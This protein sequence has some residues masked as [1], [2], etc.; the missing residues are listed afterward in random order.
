MLLPGST[1]WTDTVPVFL[2]VGVLVFVPGLAAGLLLRLRPLA[3]LAL[4]PLLSTTCLG[5]TAVVAPLVGVR[6]SVATVVV[7]TLALWV[8]AFGAGILLTRAN[9][10]LAARRP[11]WATWLEHPAERRFDPV[12][13]WTV[14]SV[15]VTLLVVLWT[16]RP[17]IRTPEALPQAP[18]TIFHVAAP[19]WGLQHGTLSSLQIGHF[20]DPAA[21]FYPGAFYAFTATASLL[22]GAS[23]VVCTSVYVVLLAGVV[24][25]LGCIVLA[26]S[27]LGRR[28]LVVLAT[29]LLSVAFTT[30]PYFLMGFGVLWPNLLG[31]AIL[32]AALAALVG[33]FRPRATP[34]YAV[35]DRVRSAAVLLVA[36]PG[37][38][39]AHPNAFVTLGV[40]GALIVL[41]RVWEAARSQRSGQR[42]L[43]ILGGAV[44]AL[45]VVAVVSVLVRPQF[46]VDTGAPGPERSVLGA[47]HDLLLFAPRET[48]PLPVLSALV[49]IGVVVLLRRHRGARW[50]VAALVVMLAL[51]WLNI[52]VDDALVRYLTWPW[53]NNAVRLHAVAIL[54]AVLAGAAA[55]VAI[56]DL[57]ARL[58]TRRWSRTVVA[59]GAAA[60]VLGAAALDTGAQVSA[61]RHILHRYFHP[62]PADSW[63]SDQE[64]RA[65]RSLSAHLPP[66]AVV[67]ANPWN[68]PTYLYVVSGRR[69]LIPTEKGRTAGDRTLLAKSLDRV[70]TDP[71]VCA[72]ATRQHVAWAITGGQPF[73]WA[74]NR[75]EEYAG[76]DHVGSSAAWRE[77]AHAAP[78]TLYERVAC[79]GS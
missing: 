46:M 69:L 48:H 7:G 49:A 13:W 45:V 5:L 44:V 31:Q 61:H 64:L 70:G 9:T 25:P 68:G 6:W 40:F 60:L 53:Y 65:L 30:Y 47:F 59:V 66:D 56:A 23:V 39:L 33:V 27:L 62:K 52:A 26:L 1:S 14:A 78:Y 79:A 15:V 2:V 63:V 41:G 11:G 42:R 29:A 37:L 71:K 17:E 57:V 18:D 8:I 51:Y 72:A 77:V 50:V 24:W 73:S 34:P 54:P 10:A 4:A 12:L 19:Q 16:I 28:V 32:P 67:A 20:N 36:V 58:A 3:A 22:T 21:P 38:V 55:L 74:G 75:V 76:I 43:L 35:G